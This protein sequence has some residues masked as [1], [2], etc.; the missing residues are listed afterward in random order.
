MPGGGGPPIY[1][2]TY[3]GPLTQDVEELLGRFQQT[4]SVRYETFSAI[5][6]SMSFSDVFLGTIEMCE[7]RRFCRVAFATASKYF[8]GPFSYQIRVGGLYLLYGFYNTQLAVPQSAI[9]L[10]L[11]DWPY[12]QNFLKESVQSRH[13]DV[14]YILGKLFATKA[15]HFVAMPHFLTFRKHRN[16]RI[17]PLCA[18]FL[19]RTQRVQELVYTELQDEVSNVQTLYQSMMRGVV[20]RTGLISVVLPDFPSRL[21]DTAAEFVDWQD[22]NFPADGQE[23]YTPVEAET[24]KR[25]QLLTSIKRKSYSSIRVM[26]RSRRHRQPVA[27]TVEPSGS[28]T[29]QQLRKR[30]PSLRARTWKNLAV[31]EEPTSFVL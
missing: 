29:D 25:A 11:K 24:T 28:G 6:R 26:G 14:I 27:S 20:E 19:S 1:S 23:G 21:N 17:E 18:G 15:I 16:H 9:R 13:Y 30:P 8:L 5:W 10:A 4:D 22:K 12:V 7:M 31:R 3:Y 2:D